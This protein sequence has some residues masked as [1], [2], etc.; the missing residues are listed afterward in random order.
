MCQIMTVSHIRH[1]SN[2]PVQSA[3]KE[4]YLQAAAEHRP[5]NIYPDAVPPIHDVLSHVATDK[6]PS[7]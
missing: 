2:W 4:T 7:E 5:I 6:D 3:L 1:N